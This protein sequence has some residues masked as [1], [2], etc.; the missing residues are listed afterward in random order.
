MTRRRVSVHLALAFDARCVVGHLARAVAGLAPV[1]TAGTHLIR[2]E[3]A[4]RV[5]TSGLQPSVSL[6]SS[7]RHIPIGIRSNKSQALLPALASPRVLQ[8]V[9]W[10]SDE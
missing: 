8:I 5:S 10:L 4:R 6:V 3:Y 7:G 2:E 1:V 9:G